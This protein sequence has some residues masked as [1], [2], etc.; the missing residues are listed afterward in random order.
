MEKMNK[1]EKNA[2]LSSHKRKYGEL[3]DTTRKTLN[4]I[5][6]WTDKLAKTVIKNVREQFEFEQQSRVI[7]RFIVGLVEQ[8]TLIAV[9]INDGYN[10][11]YSDGIIARINTSTRGD[12]DSDYT[13]DNDDEYND[14]MYLDTLESTLMNDNNGK[15]GVSLN[16]ISPSDLK[17][18][19]ESSDDEAYMELHSDIELREDHLNH[20]SAG[21]YTELMDDKGSWKNFC[22]LS[23]FVD[24]HGMMVASIVLSFNEDRLPSD[25]WELIASYLSMSVSTKTLVPVA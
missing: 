21:V 15:R 19:D 4:C 7:H 2:R 10:V 11:S 6:P 14:F 24:F 18:H 17:I 5:P 13:D 8:K 25:L 1:K 3:T 9:G 12:L 22:N 20:P 23:Y 16:I